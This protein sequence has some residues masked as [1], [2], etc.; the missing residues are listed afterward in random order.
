METLAAQPPT[1][2]SS[3]SEQQEGNAAMATLPKEIATR[4]E[5]RCRLCG[6]EG[7][8]IYRGESDRLFGAPGLWNLRRCKSAN[9]SLLWLDPTPREAELH[10]AY[11]TYY[12][13]VSPVLDAAPGS[14]RALF[15]AIKRGYLAL[16]YGYTSGQPKP[17]PLLGTLLYLLP[18]RRSDLDAE[19]R[20]LG[21]MPGGRLLDVGC[22]SGEWMD[23]MRTMG[24]QVEGIDFDENAVAAARRKG[25]D[26]R[27][28]TIDSQNYP[29]NAFDVVN[30]NHV[31]EHVPDPVGLLREIRRIL[32]PGGKLVLATPNASSICHQVFGRH[33]RGLEPPRHL[34]IFTP[35]SMLGALKAAGFS[36]ITLRTLGS[37]YVW[38]QSLE[39]WLGPA[40]RW[41]PF[42]RAMT[43]VA[44]RLLPLLAQAWLVV[45]PESGECFA[46]DA[47]K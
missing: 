27:T 20:F 11:A 25:L 36:A 3:T 42:K 38:K 24:W 41:T 23:S 29:E 30:L 2:Q 35:P 4:P 40:E 21:A 31:I 28:G 10:K 32:K 9:C 18:V 14:L 16:R 7:D 8:W 22:G 15:R 44:V 33:W 45:R 17:N 1:G 47:V 34:Q 19:I 43:A 6:S 39:L 37:V 5:P 46:V 13:H 12:T 26:V